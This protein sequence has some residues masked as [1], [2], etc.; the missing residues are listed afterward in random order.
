[1]V[2]GHVRYRTS[3]LRQWI[4]GGSNPSPVVPFRALQLSKPNMTLSGDASG[5]PVDQTFFRTTRP[6]KKPITLLFAH[7]NICVMFI[8]IELDEIMNSVARRI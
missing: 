8:L 6:Q 2:M 3:L 4:I 7:A 5:T 1:M